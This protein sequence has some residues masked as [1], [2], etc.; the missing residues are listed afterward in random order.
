M[1]TVINEPI[2]GEC[3]LESFTGSLKEEYL[4]IFTISCH[5]HR[6][7]NGPFHYEF[8]LIEIIEH[9]RHE[10]IVR[11]FS[12]HNYIEIALE[13]TVNYVQVRVR[14]RIGLVRVERV[15]VELVPM[16][17]KSRDDL[18][19]YLKQEL[20]YAELIN[21]E[22]FLI[23]TRMYINYCVKWS[24]EI[25]NPDQ[26]INK[27]GNLYKLSS[28]LEDTQRLTLEEIHLLLGHLGYVTTPYI[29]ILNELITTFNEY[30]PVVKVSKRH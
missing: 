27:I 19:N 16:F 23:K 26:L 18:K 28:Y 25:E 9:D 14:D 30:L 8:S 17:S 11:E 6:S 4:S 20:L 3:A 7:R 22:M 1:V 5:G 21:S 13:P 12:Q 10:L 2:D 24:Y 29:E 15:D